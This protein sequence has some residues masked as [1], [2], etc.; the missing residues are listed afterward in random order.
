M[1]SRLTVFLQWS[2]LIMNRRLRECFSSLL[3]DWLTQKLGKEL[4]LCEELHVQHVTI[5]RWHQIHCKFLF[6]AEH[7]QCA[8]CMRFEVND[9]QKIPAQSIN[10][11]VFKR[12]ETYLLLEKELGG[13]HSAQLGY[14]THTLEEFAGQKWTEKGEMGVVTLWNLH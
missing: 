6:P 13:N 4:C 5:K 10:A 12:I 9:L 14:L 1:T 3:T 11:P 7:W 2:A 8:E